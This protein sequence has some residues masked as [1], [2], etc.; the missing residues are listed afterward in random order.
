MRTVTL[1]AHEAQLIAG[2]ACSSALDRPKP[3]SRIG[4]KSC[5]AAATVR[6]PIPMIDW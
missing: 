1:A 6:S 3:P 5:F 4:M 2:S